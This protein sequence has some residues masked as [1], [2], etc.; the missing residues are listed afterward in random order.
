MS[1]DLK[2]SIDYFIFN[3][4]ILRRS[5]LHRALRRHQRPPC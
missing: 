5:L 1:S 4:P 2:L 3:A